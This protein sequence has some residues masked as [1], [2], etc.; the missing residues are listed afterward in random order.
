MDSKQK[1]EFILVV[2]G[3]V[4]DAYSKYTGVVNEGGGILSFN[5]FSFISQFSS[6]KYNYL[7]VFELE[8]HKN[9]IVSRMQSP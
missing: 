5:F 4:V 6:A 1:L 9:Y 3:K 8:F 7:L 2:C